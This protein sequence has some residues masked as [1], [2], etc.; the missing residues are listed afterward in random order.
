MGAQS[1]K[2]SLP[3]ND[4]EG[5]SSLSSSARVPSGISPV[6]REAN[7][8]PE[9]NSAQSHEC[10]ENESPST[11]PPFDDRANNH[12]QSNT[13]LT[14]P[15]ATTAPS[16]SFSSRSS[17]PTTPPSTTP[18]SRIASNLTVLPLDTRPAS[19]AAASLNDDAHQP[20]N[21]T[22]SPLGEDTTSVTDGYN[23]TAP[24]VTNTTFEF[25]VQ[26]IP[27]P[28]VSIDEVVQPDQLRVPYNF[29]PADT[30]RPLP[31]SAP[32][33]KRDDNCELTLAIGTSPLERASHEDA[34]QA[35]ETVMRFIEQQGTGFLSFQ[36]SYHLGILAERLRLQSQHGN[37]VRQHDTFAKS[38]RCMKAT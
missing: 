32:D 10:L 34:L 25:P 11:A 14:V 31:I 24:L 21:R 6:S 8:S 4:S 13:S 30:I 2:S 26:D 23:S 36:E 12:S 1:Q 28:C 7:Q 18:F 5:L 22:R 17:S 33:P 35:L 27:T 37:Q 3:R 20:H 16:S 9:L 38:S 15:F 19:P 29:T